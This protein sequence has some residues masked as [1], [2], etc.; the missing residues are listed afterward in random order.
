[1]IEIGRVSCIDYSTGHPSAIMF[2]GELKKRIYST[3]ASDELTCL[4]ELNGFGNYI[5]E[6][7]SVQGMFKK[8]ILNGESTVIKKNGSLRKGTFIKSLLDGYGTRVRP[9]GTVMQGKFTKG[10]LCG[11]GKIVIA[12]GEI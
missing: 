10:K 11:V 3:E 7:S 2:E 1:M 9:N 4:Y 12:N 8:H 5:T 6:T